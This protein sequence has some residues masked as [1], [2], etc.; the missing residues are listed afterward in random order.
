MINRIYFVVLMFCCTVVYND[1]VA[2]ISVN[3]T[4][5]G[6]NGY[7]KVDETHENGNH[8]LTCSGVGLESCC[9]EVSPSVSTSQNVYLV[10]DIMQDVESQLSS[11]VTDGS[12]SLDGEYLVQWIGSDVNNYQLNINII[13]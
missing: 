4:G 6:T 7:D 12:Y 8:S 5:G 10:A 9:W 1:V 13:E 2:G 3:V 11:G